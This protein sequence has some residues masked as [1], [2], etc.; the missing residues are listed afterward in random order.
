[1]SNLVKLICTECGRENYHTQKNKKKNPKILE[2][3]KYCRFLKKHTIHKEK[4]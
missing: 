2:F 1:M 3:K 4:K